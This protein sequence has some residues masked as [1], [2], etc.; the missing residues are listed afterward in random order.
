MKIL[1][2]RG[3]WKTVQEKNTLSAFKR[4]FDLGFGVETDFRDHN[5]QLVVFHDL[6]NSESMRADKMFEMMSLVDSSLPLAINIKADGLQDLLKCAIKKFQI[7]DYFLFDMSVPDAIVSIKNGLR[8][9]TRQSDLEKHP[10][11]YAEAD[12][13]WIDAFYNDG[14]INEDI[15]KSHLNAGKSVCL[16][17]PE[18]H[19][20]FHLN[21]WNRLKVNQ[22]F[23]DNSVLLCTDLPEDAAKFF[24]L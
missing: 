4:S 14:W 2:H 24:K 19:K 1:S 13:V 11:F 7:R 9:F 10:A 21:L 22:L 3:Y 17:S 16:V 23:N 6:P 20:R 12:G 5:G 18:V 15:I 8:V